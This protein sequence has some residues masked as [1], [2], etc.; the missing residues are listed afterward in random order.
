VQFVGQG[1]DGGSR[2]Q[3]DRDSDKGTHGKII[4]GRK[5][6][7]KL[8]KERTLPVSTVKTFAQTLRVVAR[9]PSSR[10]LRSLTSPV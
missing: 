4:G 8:L 1:Q 7:M 6:S 9:A 10:P 2:R 5:P 3:E